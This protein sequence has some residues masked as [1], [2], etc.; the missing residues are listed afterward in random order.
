MQK[1]EFNENDLVYYLFA[2]VTRRTFG[3]KGATA[4]ASRSF[5]QFILEPLYKILAHVNRFD[6]LLI[7]I[8]ILF[9]RWLVMLIALFPVFLMN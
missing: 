9:F 8:R 7:L 2:D 5:I 4:N 6:F 1:R 3:K